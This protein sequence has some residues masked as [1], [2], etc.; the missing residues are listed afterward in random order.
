[1]SRILV[2][3]L[4]NK[5]AGEVHGTVDRGWAINDGGEATI[6]LSNVEASK[7]FLQLGRLIYVDGGGNL[8]NWAGMIDTPW[9]AKSPVEVKAYDLNSLMGIRRPWNSEKIEGDTGTVALHLLELSNQLGDLGL[10]EGEIEDGGKS[11][12][13]EIT[14]GA[15]TWAQIQK[16]A[17]D[18]GKEL[19]FRPYFADK[20][21][22]IYLD[23]K[24]KLGSETQVL[25][26]DGERGN[27][28]V[29]SAEVRGELFNSVRA[30]NKGSTASNRLGS[31]TFEDEES[32]GKYRRRNTLIQVSTTSQ[33]DLEKYADS[34]LAGNAWPTL[35]LQVAA[36]DPTMNKVFPYLRLGNTINLRATQLI[37][38]GGKIGWS[39]QVRI[40]AMSYEETNNL[41][42]MNVE[43]SIHE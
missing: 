5:L 33:S 13:R 37:L 28:Q 42:K 24:T 7:P 27:M 21:L 12:N 26:T 40:T 43:G 6:K 34:Y 31:D 30:I 32:I 8:P 19:Q 23:L 3:D 9:K 17:Q 2:F 18:K 25:L 14:N 16:L 11:I 38:P 15:T 4:D 35:Y 22:V 29:T 1:M 41:V 39:G 36:I 20:Q 10:R